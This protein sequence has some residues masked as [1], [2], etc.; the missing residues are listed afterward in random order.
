MRRRL[1]R[2]LFGGSLVTIP[3]LGGTPRQPAGYVPP[4]LPG[5][6]AGSFQGVVRARLVVVFGTGAGSGLFVYNGTPA[7][8]NPPIFWATS[9]TAD[10]FGNAIPST[11]GV[12][13]TGT[14]RAGNTITNT[15]GEFFYSGTPAANNLIGS[16]ANA[17]GTDGFGNAYVQGQ[18]SYQQGIS[19]WT[20]IA[21]QSVT[22]GAQ[23]AWYYTTGLTETGWI[24]GGSF[25]FAPGVSSPAGTPLQYQANGQGFLIGAASAEQVSLNGWF[26]VQEQ[27]SN[28]SAKS[29]FSTQWT[30]GSGYPRYLAGDTADSVVYNMGARVQ[31]TSV[32]QTI[33]STS[34]TTI[35]GLDFAVGAGTYYFEAIIR[36]KQGATNVPQNVGFTGPTQSF[37]VWYQ[38]TSQQ[39]GTNGITFVQG[40]PLAH[41]T[42]SFVAANDE[43]YWYAEGVVTFSAAGTFQA[44]AAEG[45]AGDT[46]TIQPGS[47][48]KLR[49][50]R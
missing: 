45:T 27:I 46:F 49:P 5:V 33:S 10:P 29:G 13:G 40:A 35:T 37:A 1:L 11:A 24:A 38:H 6:A 26:Q 16:I 23:F 36:L 41:V 20:A 4:S 18:A 2:T 47:F 42:V 12:A 48:V 39:G 21:S 43:D 22:G 32:A 25:S 28:P 7:A 9:A 34:D 44:V 14:F 19:Q 31:F 8:G 50:M 15:S 30:N 3:G 17:A